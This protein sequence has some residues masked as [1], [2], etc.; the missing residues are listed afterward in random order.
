MCVWGRIIE[1]YFSLIVMEAIL[2]IKTDRTCS[3]GQPVKRFFHMET[4]EDM[5]V[6]ELA[7]DRK[8]SDICV[9]ILIL[10]L[11]E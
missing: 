9:G 2:F 11:N 1:I 10:L 3:W 6:L 5:P 8:P 7:P 4:T